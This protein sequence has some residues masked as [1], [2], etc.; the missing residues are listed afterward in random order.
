MICFLDS[1]AIVKQYADEQH[2]SAVRAFEGPHIVSALARVE[3]AAAF[4]RKHRM[5]QLSLE[6]TALLCSVFE[7]DW[8]DPE[9][10]GCSYQRIEP[11]EAILEAAVTL[12]GLHGLRG[13][14]AIHLASA[15]AARREIPE[16]SAFV[17][18]DHDLRR[19]AAAL[20]FSILPDLD[21]P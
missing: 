15:A 16:C 1:S 13:Y 10:T 6:N 7:G 11:V 9:T 8:F 14:D 17:A 21:R 19:A 5:R 2:S 3:V 18:F 4:W 20:G 12:A